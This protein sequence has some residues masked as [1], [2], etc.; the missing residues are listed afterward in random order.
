MFQ[1]GRT[2]MNNLATVVERTGLDQ[3]E[4]PRILRRPNRVKVSEVPVDL[5]TV[6]QLL[7]Y[8]TESALLG[9]AR[10]ITYANVHVANL[11]VKSQWFRRF[12]SEE[13]SA[14]FCDGV[15]LLVG[16]R[17]L[18]HKVE[19]DQRMT[20]PD[21]F[22][23]LAE[24]CARK[25][26]SVYLLAGKPGVIEG[27]ISRVRRTVP[28]LQIHGHHGYFGKEGRENDAIVREINEKRP[29]ILCL[30][31][32]SP[33]QERWILENKP[34]LNVRVYLP[35]GACL[36]YYS[37]T[38]WRGP[39]WLTD[40]GAEWLCR[41]LIEPGRLWKRYVLGNPQFMMRVISSRA[42]SEAR[43]LSIQLWTVYKDRR[44][45]CLPPY[46]GSTLEART[47]AGDDR[48]MLV[49]EE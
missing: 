46:K 2:T 48:G 36:D 23:Q 32:G 18:G 47:G 24:N 12:L 44:E 42:R 41:L 27:A 14:V 29:D 25:G 34:R 17:I 16:A 11:A 10:I 21:F 39:R 43:R 7:E 3:A 31:L 35:I 49:H 38:I 22:E 26:L 8:I 33:L 6:D 37:G 4:V 5:F 19:S 15:G 45:S 20:A 30:G 40:N 28:T 1:L 9:E 13:T